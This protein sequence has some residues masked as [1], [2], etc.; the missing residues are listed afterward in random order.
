MSDK[1]TSLADR[2]AEYLLSFSQGNT[3][4]RLI[5]SLFFDAANEVASEAGG[6]DF[7]GLVF[8]ADESAMQRAIEKAK[9]CYEG[10]LAADKDQLAG[11]MAAVCLLYLDLDRQLEDVPATKQIARLG[12]F[13]YAQENRFRISQFNKR[14]GSASD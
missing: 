4:N 11:A 5:A 8:Y 13:L 1:P 10:A 2:G 14:S 6:D 12:A 7:V 3:D 9:V